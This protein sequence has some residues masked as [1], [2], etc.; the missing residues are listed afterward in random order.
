MKGICRLCDNEKELRESHVIPSFVYKWIKN[1]SGGGSLRFGIEPNKRVQD[2]YKFYWMCNDCEGLLNAWETEFAN[3]FFH[4]IISGD[5]SKV[6]YGP[7]LLKFCASVSWRVLNLFMEEHNLSHCPENLQKC[8]NNA[9]NVWKEFLLDKQPHPNKHEQHLILLDAIESY[10]GGDMPTNIN[11]YILRTVDID[12]VC[13]GNSAFVYSKLER[14][15]ILG[16][17][18]MPKPRQWEGS[19]IHVKQGIVGPKIRTLQPQFV[20]YFMS[21]ANRMAGVQAKISDRQNKKINETFKKNVDKIATSETY[22]A[23]EHDVRLFGEKAFRKD[24]KDKK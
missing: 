11:R 12:T 1:S 7:W 23:M 8:A 22:R 5:V 24:N 9:F 14:F 19:K 16:F 18:E 2:G 15:V 17:I 6:S 20:E 3:K 13:G 21:K 10:T 4:P